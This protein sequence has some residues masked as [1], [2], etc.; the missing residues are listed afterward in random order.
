MKE[1]LQKLDIN[2]DEENKNDEKNEEEEEEEEENYDNKIKEEK[3][4]IKVK[5][6]K[7]KDDEY[8]LSFIKKAG[9]LE[10]F[11]NNIKKITEQVKKI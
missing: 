5:L 10:E 2:N 6:F 9:E 4:K 8:L 7:N 1:E 3:N 11:Y